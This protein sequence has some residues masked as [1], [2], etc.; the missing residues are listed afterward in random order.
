ML[1]RSHDDLEHA[2]MQARKLVS[3]RALISAAAAAL[4]IPGADLSTDV[5]LLL[6]ILPK[7]NALF[8]LTPEQVAQLTPEGKSLVLVG[9]ANLSIGLLGKLI[10]PARIVQLLTRLG[11]TKLLGKYGARYVPI[12]GTAVSSG[13]SYVV[14]RQVGNQHINECYEMAKKLLEQ[15]PLTANPDTIAR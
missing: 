12:L 8:G 14:L 15:L 1:I 5:A 13:L 3:R 10:T 7:I 4:P 11:A 6:Q 9:S 2:K